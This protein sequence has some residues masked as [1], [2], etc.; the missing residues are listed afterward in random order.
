MTPVT[1]AEARP[2]LLDLQRGRLPAARAAE[3]RAHVAGCADCTHAAEAEAALSE[4]L[5]HRLPQHAASLAFKRALRERWPAPAAAPRS[6]HRRWRVLAPAVALVLLASVAVPLVWERGVRRPEREAVAALTGE[7]V[8]D[9]LRV[10]FSQRPLEIESGGIHNVRPWFA[11]R[12][13]FAPIVRFEGDAD[14]PLQGG[15]VGYFLDRRAAVLVYHHRRH[16]LSLFVFRSDGLRWPRSGLEPVGRL[17][18]RAERLRGFNVLLWRQDEL[19]YALV[20]DVEPEALRA[21]AE[22]LAAP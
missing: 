9:H 8:N 17:R 13:D 20:S 22:R 7:A 3:V 1:C 2:V 10:L 19:G 12:L 16:V 6:W 4:V 11:G 15:A 21:L 14:F 18:A 5:E